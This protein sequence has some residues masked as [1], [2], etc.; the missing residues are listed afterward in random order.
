MTRVCCI[1]VLY[2]RRGSSGI[3]VLFRLGS[4]KNNTKI[5]DTQFLLGS[6]TGNSKLNY[7]KKLSAFWIKLP[8]REFV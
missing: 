8:N 5:S 3:I 6:L 2:S 4:I 7:S 1:K